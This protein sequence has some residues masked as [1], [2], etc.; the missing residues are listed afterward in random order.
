M[1][2]AG[3]FGGWLLT[4]DG[5]KFGLTCAH[6]LPGC[7]VGNTV[8]SPSTTEITARLDNIIRYTHLCPQ[9]RRLP[10]SKEREAEVALLKA[11]YM[12]LPDNNGVE[13]RDG[14]KIKLIGPDLGILIA[15]RE[16]Y[17]PILE[18]HNQLLRSHTRR[19]VCLESAIAQSRLDW[20]IFKGSESRVLGNL[21][22]S[23]DFADKQITRLGDIEPGTSVIKIGRTTGQTE[24]IVNGAALQI[25][26]TG[27]LTQ[28]VAVISSSG[29][30][31]TGCFAT[32]GD[33]GSLVVS[34][35]DPLEAV[36][37]VVG[38]NDSGIPRWVAVTPLWAVIEDVERVIGKEVEFCGEV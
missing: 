10:R 5:T 3:S 37:L 20:A 12:Q 38:K 8:A 13:L 30:T 24:G 11:Q 4:Q 15:K 34:L 35:A 2:E 14:S 29:G 19:E 36:G 28:E 6:C 25:W 17:T 21:L 16:H 18:R 7:L 9:S 23:D 31:D 27:A 33:S 32:I 1:L 26:E 22:T